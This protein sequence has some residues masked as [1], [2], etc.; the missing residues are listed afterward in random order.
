MPT[1]V[2]IAGGQLEGAA[3]A[4]QVHLR[5]VHRAAAHRRFRGDVPPYRG[6]YAEAIRRPA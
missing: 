6:L 4:G 5:E 3:A 2:R 1:A